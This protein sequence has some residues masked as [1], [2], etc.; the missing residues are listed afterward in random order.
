MNCLNQN[1]TIFLYTQ[2]KLMVVAHVIVLLKKMCQA[3]W[4]LCQDSNPRCLISG[5]NMPDTGNYFH[6]LCSLFHEQNLDDKFWYRIQQFTRLC[7]TGTCGWTDNSETKSASKQA[8]I[9]A[10]EMVPSTTE[11]IAYLKDFPTKLISMPRLCANST[12]GMEKHTHTHT[13]T[14][15]PSLLSQSSIQCNINSNLHYRNVFTVSVPW[16]AL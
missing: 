13:H 14:H 16:L 3:S 15:T 10:E 1:T 9:Q 5:F 7:L 11:D 4:I 6:V 8:T 12:F 2:S